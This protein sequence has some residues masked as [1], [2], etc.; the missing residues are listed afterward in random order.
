MPVLE[1]FQ[2]INRDVVR[3]FEVMIMTSFFHL[4]KSWVTID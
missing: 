4:H 1:L 3:E 2:G